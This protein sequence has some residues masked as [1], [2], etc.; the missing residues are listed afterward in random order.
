[1]HAQ[2]RGPRFRRRALGLGLSIALSLGLVACG[3]SPSGTT[4]AGT[5][6]LATGTLGG[7]GSPAPD[8]ADPW[9]TLPLAAAGIDQAALS[10]AEARATDLGF[11]RSLVVVRHGALVE[12]RYFGGAT[13]DTRADIRSGTKSVVALLTGIATAEG[14]LA[15]PSERLDALLRPPVTVPTGPKAAITVGDLLTMRG[16][17]DWDESTAAAYNAWALAPNQV[18]Y[19]LERPLAHPPGTSFQYD[20][21]AVHLLSVGLSQAT[22]GATETYARRSLLGPLGIA[23]DTWETDDQGFNNGGSGLALRPADYARIGQLV[24]QRGASGGRQIVP[25]AWIEAMLATHVTVSAHIGS[26]HDLRYGYLW[27]LGTADGDDVQFA[28]GYR[29]QFL[30][31]VPARDLVVVVTCVLGDASID[32]DAEADGA[33]NLIVSDLLPGVH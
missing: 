19:L 1:M 13:A 32:P 33:M 14:V 21:A 3:P 9:P 26:L 22:G 29:G 20:T 8:L 11:V 31:I 2:A 23:A 27:W 7:A 4:T 16:G 25:A 18:D 28:W 12:E 15:G 5:A 6:A 10:A 24:L 30:L 17:F